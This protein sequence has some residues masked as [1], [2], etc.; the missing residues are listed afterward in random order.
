LIFIVTTSLLSVNGSPKID[1][2]DVGDVYIENSGSEDAQQHFLHGLAQLHNFEYWSAAEDFQKV[3]QIDPDFALAYWGEA[4]TYNHTIWMRQDKKAALKALNKYASSP[5]KR[6][7]KA[8]SYL[9]RDLLKAVD[10]LYGEGTKQQQDDLYLSFMEKLHNKYPKNVEIASFYALAIMGT[11]HEGRDFGLYMQSAAVSQNFIKDYPRHPGIAHY[12]IHATD[13]PTHA[14]LGLAAANAYG[15]IA[16][17]AGHPQHMTSHIFLALGDW[18]GVIKAN[19]RAMDL[20]NAKRKAEGKGPTGCGHYASWLQYGYLQQGDQ[21]AAHDMMLLC[22][23]NAQEDKYKRLSSYAWQRAL[24]LLDTEDWDG[25]VAQMSV[26]F[27]DDHRALFEN[28]LM[29]GWI[30]VKTNNASAARSQLNN[31]NQTFELIK[32]DWE[33]KKLAK[34]QPERKLPIVQL[35]QLEA[36][37][38][39]L[40]GEQESAVKIL[41][42]AVEIE[43]ALPFGFGPPKPAKPSL[44][45]LGEVL[46]SLKMYDEAKTVLE[47][48]LKRTPNKA[49][50]VKALAKIGKIIKQQ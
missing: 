50:T 17:N 29:D 30:A 4:L 41:R 47:S 32:Q 48:S 6:E 18:K 31:A 21:L 10:I 19:I 12:L 14:P 26:S 5:S 22:H 27:G 33:S 20:T 3:Q 43:K 36:L 42:E 37:I 46:I 38:V 23:Q 9:E 8:K 16:P 34:D 25:D 1:L 13:D 15:D 2:S 45:L 39:L 11:A 44:E 49:L 24:Y 7:K 35:K 40:E 28:Q